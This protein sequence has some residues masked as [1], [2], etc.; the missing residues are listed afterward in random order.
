MLGQA[1]SLGEG[2]RDGAAVAR[3]MGG[4][5]GTQDQSEPGCGEGHGDKQDE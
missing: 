2:G 3:H 1:D 4:L 5:P